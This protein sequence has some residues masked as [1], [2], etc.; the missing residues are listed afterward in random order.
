[1]TR[2]AGWTR[3]IPTPML[4]LQVFDKTL[5]GLPTKADTE[6]ENTEA[7][8]PKKFYRL[9]LFH[10][11]SIRTYFTLQVENDAALHIYKP[12]LQVLCKRYRKGGS[13]C[14]GGSRGARDESWAGRRRGGRNIL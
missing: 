8:M 5:G 7:E 11:T 2:K 3:R 14:G 4:N 12:G 13:S 1:M 9:L 10:S 6:V